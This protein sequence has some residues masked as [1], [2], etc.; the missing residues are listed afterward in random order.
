MSATHAPLKA[1]LADT[2]EAPPTARLNFA[3]DTGFQKELRRRVDAHLKAQGLPERDVPR[4]Y[5]KSVLVL[6]LFVLS[7]VALVFVARTW[8]QALPLTVLLGLATA[9]IGF[10]IQH[11]GGHRAYSNHPWLNKLTAMTLDL[12][13][14][15]SYIWHW[16]HVVF[17]HMYVNV[18]GHDVDIDLGILGRLS[19]QQPHRPIYRWQQWY[20]WPLYGL[21]AIKWHLYDD[22]HE[23]ITGRI[24]NRQ[25]PRPRGWALTVF[26]LG[27]LLFFTLAFG[28]P[29]LRHSLGAVLLFYAITVLV[30]GVTLSVVFQLAHAVEEASFPAPL[31]GTTRIEEAWA[32]HQAANTVDFAR[33]NRSLS[34]L[35]GGLNFQIEHH[36]FPTI[37]HVNYPPIS[38]VVEKTCR[39]FGVP[40]HVHS[41]LR[42]A[43]ASHFRWLKRMGRGEETV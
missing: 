29:L 4:M 36:L 37:C 10:N 35:L 19:P 21:M 16:R 40:Y 28:I 20:L 25:F 18:A 34:W 23:V 38:G 8:W 22:F 24:G 1:A 41:S 13:G 2:R 17:H 43:V 9:E 6:A 5:L 42:A 31:P 27:K 12:I 33:G 15:S 26:V 11:D 39:E 14:G 7:Y 32:V 30:L 3:P